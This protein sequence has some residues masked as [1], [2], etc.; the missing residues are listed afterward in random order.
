[1]SDRFKCK[2]PFALIKE[3]EMQNLHSIRILLFQKFFLKKL[4]RTKREM[5]YRFTFPLS[6]HQL[7]E[8]YTKYDK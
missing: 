1:M 7:F 5:Q 6:E 4:Y 3:I 2:R 8:W